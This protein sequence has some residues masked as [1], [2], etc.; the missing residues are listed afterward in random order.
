MHLKAGSFAHTLKTK[1]VHRIWHILKTI[2]KNNIFLYL[3]VV[4][5]MYKFQ[6]YTL[7]QTLVDY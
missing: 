1:N 4:L 3:L 5:F 2:V 6:Y 7:L